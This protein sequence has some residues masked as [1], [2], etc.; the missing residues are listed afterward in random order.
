MY[1]IAEL[2][3]QEL[4]MS[5]FANI[6]FGEEITT[7]E[8][9]DRLSVPYLDDNFK[10]LQTQVDILD[11][12]LRSLANTV[13]VQNR[14]T[15]NQILDINTSILNIQIEIQTLN[16]SIANI[17][18][19]ANTANLNAQNALEVANFAS[20]RAEAAYNLAISFEASI[21]SLKIE[22]QNLRIEMPRFIRPGNVIRLYRAQ[23][24]E[25]SVTDTR[26]FQVSSES[27]IW[28]FRTYQTAGLSFPTSF[29]LPLT[30]A[31]AGD[32]SR[33]G[34]QVTGPRYEI[35]EGPVQATLGDSDQS[36]R[37][38]LR[39][40]SDNFSTFLEETRLREIE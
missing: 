8:A 33:P 30:L 18:A 20:I 9:L 5:S 26:I 34:I 38:Y 22:T 14:Q 13:D 24:E 23:T 10:S 39:F 4:L 36:N 12:N 2:T 40:V 25:R 6:V 27:A 31:G 28:S 17:T 37:M 1:A 3:H 35:R 16:N 29:V 7:F 11:G 32:N 21:N 19:L 15:Q